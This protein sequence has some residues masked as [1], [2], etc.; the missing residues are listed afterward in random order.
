LKLNLDIFPQ[1]NKN[2]QFFNYIHLKGIFNLKE[3]KELRGKKYLDKLH[4]DYYYLN[5]SYI[6][7][8]RRD[9][10]PLLF[11][12]HI[13]PAI[14][15]PPYIV[16]FHD[17]LP[18]EEEFIYG[19]QIYDQKRK[20][21]ILKM[22]A[23]ANRLLTVSNYSKKMIMSLFKKHNYKYDEKNIIVLPAFVNKQIFDGTK[24]NKGNKKKSKDSKYEI[25]F[26]GTD[27]IRKNHIN[28]IISIYILNKK[29]KLNASL[30]IVT[31]K[32]KR[33]DELKALIDIYDNQLENK[34]TFTEYVKLEDL[35]DL[36]QK[37]D[38]LLFPSY[39]E[40]FG[41]PP[42]E[43]QSM[44]L[45]VV[46]SNVS[47]MPEILGEGA[48]YVDPYDPQDIAEG[49]YRVLTDLDLKNRLVNKGFTNSA[50]YTSD[51]YSEKLYDIV[52]DLYKEYS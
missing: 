30:T 19:T 5:Q 39:Y 34:I 35:L 23:R 41:L 50:K 49:M 1:E 3:I 12:T 15:K 17:I 44:G 45:P 21:L 51:K 32:R 47:C 25:L 28:A 52:I 9:N 20:D 38:L 42:V 8:Q 6:E 24:V 29:Y 43:A 46:A 7:H 33:Y 36:Y 11:M 31:G 14:I 27:H 40:G 13:N 2:S 26:I 4:F 18:W 10:V 48:L 22:S 37:S 16:T